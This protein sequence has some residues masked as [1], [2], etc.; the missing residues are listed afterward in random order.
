MDQQKLLIVL[1]LLVSA[2]LVFLILRR[3]TTKTITKTEVIPVH[4]PRRFRPNRR[5]PFCRHTLKGCYPGTNIPI[6]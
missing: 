3:T 1:I 5:T 2:V 4:Y 6:P